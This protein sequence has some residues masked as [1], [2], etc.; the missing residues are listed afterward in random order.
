MVFIFR[1]MVINAFYYHFFIEN[2]RYVLNEKKNMRSMRNPPY[3]IQAWSKELSKPPLT[4]EVY[5]KGTKGQ[6]K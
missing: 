4:K 2:K 1:L 5:I 6:Y 3:E